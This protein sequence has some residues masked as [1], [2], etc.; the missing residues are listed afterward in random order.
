MEEFHEMYFDGKVDFKG[1]CLEIMEYRHDWACFTFGISLFR[2]VLFG[3]IPETL[4]HT[5]SQG[6]SSYSAKLL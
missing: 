1:D 3:M 5:R 2:F 4:M 6:W